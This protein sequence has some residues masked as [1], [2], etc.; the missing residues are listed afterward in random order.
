MRRGDAEPQDQP[1]GSDE[2]RGSDATNTLALNSTAGQLNGSGAGA[3]TKRRWFDLRNGYGFYISIF[4]GFVN[5]CLLIS[6]KFPA[7]NPYLFV[8]M[9]GM[10]A[11][12]SA[13]GIGY[14]HRKK[15]LRTDQ[16]SVFEQS[17]LMARVNEIQL[18]AILGRAT[19]NE[20]EWALQ[21]LAAIRK[22]EV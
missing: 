4:L 17:H 2:L 13:T 21:L 20:I 16:D 1:L 15:Q 12:A 9:V 5:F 3:W 6:V 22:N 8:P 19:E 11:A 10:G 18:K 14:L 7:L